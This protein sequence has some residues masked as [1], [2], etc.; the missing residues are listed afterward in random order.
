MRWR[1]IDRF[2]EFRGGARAVAVKNVSLAE[3]LLRD[4]FPRY[5]IMPNSLIVEGMGQTGMYLAC[6]AIG[7]AELVLLAKVSSAR[8]YC[9]ALPGDTLTYTVSIESIQ[10]RGISVSAASRKG[11]R[12]QGEA[13]LLFARVADR[14]ADG[15]GGSLAEMAK[16]MRLLGAYE[17][18][19]GADGAR[20][21]PPAW[22]DA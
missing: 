17:I 12:L 9:E 5:P 7:Y 19:T 3:G 14:S 18:G 10:E 11:E 4:H 1:W 6:E 20:L 16:Q 22:L 13:E 2:V 21:Q 8:F 15:H